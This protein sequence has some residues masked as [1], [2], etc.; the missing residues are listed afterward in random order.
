MAKHRNRNNDIPSKSGEFP[1]WGQPRPD[2]YE[3]TYAN[4]LRC[5]NLSQADTS[6]EGQKRSNDAY[7]TLN[8][9]IFVTDFYGEGVS[10]SQTFNRED[11][12][13]ILAVHKVTPFDVLL[14]H[15]YSRLTRGGVRH[16]NSVE[17]RLRKA[18]IQVVSTTDLIPDS[19]EGEFL[20]SA[21]HYANQL[22]ARGIS[23]AVARGISQSL[24]KMMRP[25]ASRTPYGLDRLY[26]G[27]DEKPRMLVR[28]NGLVQQWL[29]PDTL[30]VVGQRIK[31]P[32]QKPIRTGKGQRP[33][34]RPRRT[35]F[36]GY[37]KQGDEVGR[38]VPGSKERM[39]TL[40]W[41][42]TAYDIWKWGYHRIIQHLNGNNIPGPGGGRWTLTSIRNVLFNPIYLGLEVRHRWSKALYN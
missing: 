16:G 21:K 37:M 34:R 38:L 28:W 36:K 33:L 17:D 29:K 3:N 18:G 1:A 2:L 7:A 40:V 8:K 20:T 42:F 31:E 9:M 27:P 39:D 14:I 4:L 12:E 30:E 35:K 32:P 15:D 11:I 26:V 22:Q 13:E 19:P 41:S 6:P 23:L 24:A 25:A 5:S 10:G